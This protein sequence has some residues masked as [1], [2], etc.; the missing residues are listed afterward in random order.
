MR[1][2]KLS[3]DT[4]AAVY[5]EF[6]VVFMPVFTLWLGMTQIGL[7]YAGDV[8]VQH[9]ADAA[10]R[11]AIVVLP[12]DPARYGGPD[13]SP[14]HQ[15]NW[16]SADD[17]SGGG[18]DPSGIGGLLGVEFSNILP[19]TGDKRLNVIRMAA[20]K[21]LLAIAPTP[22]QTFQPTPNVRAAIG[23]APQRFVT[24]LAYN[25]AA[26]AVTFPTA[27]LAEDAQI[28]GV[29]SFPY[30]RGG[31]QRLTARVT[32]L[33]NCAV[34][35]AAQIMCDTPAGLPSQS[36]QGYREL[37]GAMYP[38]F[39]EGGGIIGMLTGLLRSRFHIMRRE[40]TLLYQ[41]ADYLYASEQGATS[42]HE[43]PEGTSTTPSCRAAST[44]C[45]QCSTGQACGDS[46]ISTT[47]PCHQP[48]G[49]A[50]NVSEICP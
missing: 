22:S 31:G 40:A 19:A 23:S 45:R 47:L 8:I 15:I 35:F 39:S 17:D 37:G 13:E 33:F 5:V 25:L 6:L 50:C 46:C 43:D 24:G 30:T 3:T 28:E 48:T 49:C 14:K 7:M 9:A 27:P 1:R 20:Y 36:T 12:D 21:P 26:V 32:Y 44:C 10:A 18:G 41:G 38:I 34:P 42:D 4:R 11:S 2:R 29:Q 16:S